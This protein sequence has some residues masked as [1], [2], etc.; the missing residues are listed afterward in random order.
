[1]NKGDRAVLATIVRTFTMYIFVVAVLRIM[2][3][4]QIGELEAS[5]LVVTIIISDIAA[6]P[7][8]NTE[9]SVSVNI[10]AILTLMVM[11]LILS[12]FAY[13][14]TAVRTILYGRP[15]TFYKNG[16]FNQKEMLRQRF[17]VADIMEELR[18]SGI[19]TL[20]DVEYIVMETNGNVSV[21]LKEEASPVTPKQINIKQ[22]KVRMSYIIIDN[23]TIVKS[24]M[25]NLGLNK[26]WLKK[27][28]N[29]H[30]IKK[31]EDIFYMS[32]EE[33]SGKTVIIPKD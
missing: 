23:G 29:E 25:K 11:E 13:K 15:S 4:R 31:A 9:A 33:E 1:M 19:C 6:M 12:Y 7:I 8:T 5:E 28:M 18:G 26:E 22:N 24:C 17:N 21:I 32:F 2:G 10:I 14:I 27:K 16:K 3:K 20:D 30:G